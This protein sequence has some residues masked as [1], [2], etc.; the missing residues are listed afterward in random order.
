MKK[1]HE[2]LKP[3]FVLCRFL[4]VMVAEAENMSYTYHV[5]KENDDEQDDAHQPDADP[6]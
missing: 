5:M 1:R 6:V 3:Y 4:L 2:K